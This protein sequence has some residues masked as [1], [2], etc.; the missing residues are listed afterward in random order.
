MNLA[1]IPARKSSKRIK[2]KNII[3]FFGEPIIAK[4]I[5]LIKNTNLFKRI[6]VTIDCKKILSISKKYGAEIYLRKKKLAGDKIP[7]A[8]VIKDLLHNY[9]MNINNVFYFYPTSIFI[10]KKYL[11]DSLK[12]L[13]KKPNSMVLSICEYSHPIERSLIMNS[14]NEIKFKNKENILKQT[15]YFQKSYYDAGQFGLAKKKYFLDNNGKNKKI[16]GYVLNDYD[17]CDI[18]NY[19]DLKKA[20][21]LFKK[22]KNE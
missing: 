11:L 7:I 5:K 9:N 3:N 17:A 15:Q 12:I 22:L 20:K 4:T 2:N 19:K 1:I 6:I 18:D 14:K 10:K 21:F 16:I 8:N 13:K